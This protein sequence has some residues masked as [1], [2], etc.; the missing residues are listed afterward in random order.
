[1][2]KNF[3]ESKDDIELLSYEN[4]LILSYSIPLIIFVAI[5]PLI[6]YTI[7]PEQAVLVT[8]A[9]S[10]FLLILGFC[11]WFFNTLIKDESKKAVLFN[12]I[13][14]IG[15]AFIIIRF[16]PYIGPAVWTVSFIGI[17]FSMVRLSRVMLRAMFLTLLLLGVIFWYR[18]DLFSLGTTYYI[19]QF[20]AFSILFNVSLRVHHI[21]RYRNEKIKQQLHHIELISTISS[22]FISTSESNLDEKI[23]NMLEISGNYY[24][25]DRTYLFTFSEDQTT[26]TY[27]HEWCN[28]SIEPAIGVVIDEMPTSTVPWWMN[29]ILQN[30]IVQIPDVDLLPPLA[31]KEKELLKAQNIKSLI[32]IPVTSNG[33]VLGFIGFDSVK[34][35]K[36]WQEDHIE[37]L[38]VMSNFV[39]DV[40]AQVKA[41]KDIY[42]LAYYDPLTQLPNRTLFKEKVDI[43]LKAAQR[44]H[45]IIGIIFIDLDAFKVVNDTLGHG[46]GDELLKR[47]GDRIVAAVREQ[48]LVCRFGGDE[49][50]I[51]VNQLDKKADVK[52]VADRI[53]ATFS[54]P[55][56][57]ADKELFIRTSGG[58]AL[59]PDD[60][61]D[62]ETL[63]KNADLALHKSKDN[64][65]NH[66][67]QYTDTMKEELNQKM[68]L[69]NDLHYAL[70]R[71][72]LVIYFQPQVNAKTNKIVGLEALLRWNHPQ[73]GL[74][75]PARFI[76]LAEQSGLIHSI[77]EWVLRTACSQVKHWQDKGMPELRIAVNL[78]VEQFKKNNIV[79]IVETI[80]KDT[81]FRSSLLELELTESTTMTEES[82]VIETLNQLKQLGVTIAIDDFGTEYSCLS[83]LKKLPIDRIKVA[84]QFVHGIST[85]EKDQA[86][87]KNIINLAKSLGLEVIAEGVETKEQIEFLQRH[88]CDEFQ[89][90]YYYKPMPREEIEELILR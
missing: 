21:N 19:A 84:M 71:N 28:A 51:M 73:L 66:Y 68:V 39:A 61:K 1:M 25:V 22:D 77:G 30:G 85:N 6:Y 20:I 67:I 48:D 4:K 44:S 76:S 32:S 41:E 12:I 9:N 2:T 17:M 88:L 38:K 3:V 56:V 83:R 75:S 74:L 27:T 53:F 11:F 55:F 62:A 8:I 29:Q 47:V 72:E 40:L 63:I 24:E 42:A 70:V 59:Y 87:A 16:Y 52:L 81:Q 36:V 80:L 14:V 26:L 34:K 18:E 43:A 79:P 65:K 58:V 45:F 86:I 37:I 5:F 31:Q 23:N 78:S 69:L 89:G 10:L 64:G 50:L 13:S 46:A 90:Y 15:L 57:I 35:K 60:G 54:R 82:D 7:I 33:K 49:F